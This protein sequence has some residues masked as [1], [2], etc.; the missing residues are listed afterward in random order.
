MLR[1]VETAPGMMGIGLG[2]AHSAALPVTSPLKVGGVI[3][4]SQ[5]RNLRA[6]TCVTYPKSQLGK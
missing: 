3:T 2:A 5:T 6:E 4:V 1:G